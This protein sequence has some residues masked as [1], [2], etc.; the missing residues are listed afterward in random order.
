MADKILLKR[1]IDKT[2]LSKKQAEE[3]LILSGNDIEVNSQIFMIHI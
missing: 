3:F 2:L 1:F